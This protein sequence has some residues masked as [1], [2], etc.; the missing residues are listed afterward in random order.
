MPYA[1][2][3]LYPEA[4]NRVVIA[5]GRA[6]VHALALEKVGVNRLAQGIVRAAQPAR[7]VAGRVIGLTQFE[8]LLD[9]R[10][11]VA[12]V[13]VQRV[14]TDIALR[15]GG[16]FHHFG[17]IAVCVQLGHGKAFEQV[18]IAHVCRAD[19]IVAAFAELGDQ[20]A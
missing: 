18:I 14:H 13:Y 1:L 6:D 7:E 4:R 10:H 8:I 5:F 11:G 12:A 16:L 20:V 17:Y 15:L 19:G 2:K 3:A 9:E